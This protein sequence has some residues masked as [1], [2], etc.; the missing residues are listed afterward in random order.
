MLPSLPNF[1]A[2][3]EGAWLLRNDAGT[4]HGDYQRPSRVD[5][6][7]I[8]TSTDRYKNPTSPRSPGSAQEFIA[9]SPLEHNSTRRALRSD[10]SE[11][12]DTIVQFWSMARMLTYFAFV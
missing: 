6:P 1:Q 9:R 7:S 8:V 5:A 10:A 12:T 4:V 3:L 11:I 2:L